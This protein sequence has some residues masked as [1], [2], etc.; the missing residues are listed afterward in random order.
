MQLLSCICHILALFNRD[1][2][3]L[4][5]LI[6]LI[7]DIVFFTTA[8]CMTAQVNYEIK[9]RDALGGAHGGVS[10]GPPPY[11]APPPTVVAVPA[12]APPDNEA[13]AR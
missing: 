2:Q 11:H 6:D 13:M 9:Y 1:F 4:A 10:A 7:A 12:G 3:Q 5:A 8:G